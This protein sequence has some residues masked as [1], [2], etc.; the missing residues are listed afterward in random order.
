[1]RSALRSCYIVQSTSLMVKTMSKCRNVLASDNFLSFGSESSNRRKT[2]SK[3]LWKTIWITQIN[4]SG[5]IYILITYIFETIWITQLKFIGKIYTIYTHTHIYIF[6]SS[7]AWKP[8]AFMFYKV[9]WQILLYFNSL[10]NQ[11]HNLL[12]CQYQHHY[13]PKE[14]CYHQVCHFT[15]Y[16]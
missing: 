11:I 1:M 4:F 12:T 2:S 5:K 3:Q 13:C 14:S 15:P 9:F 8:M 10:H 16:R 6:K 7:S